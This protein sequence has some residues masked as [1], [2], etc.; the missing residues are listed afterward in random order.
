LS[1]NLSKV[2]CL[3]KLVGESVGI[4]HV[5]LIFALLAFGYLF[6]RRFAGRRSLAAAI[7][8]LARCGTPLSASSLY[9]GKRRIDGDGQLVAR[10]LCCA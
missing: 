7:G 3:P 2:K 10:Q 5:W 1:V 6:L 8:V 4:H 9:T